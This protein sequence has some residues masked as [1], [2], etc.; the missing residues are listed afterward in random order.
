MNRFEGA[1]VV[2][3][4]A[5]SGLGRD[6]AMAFAREGAARVVL[7]DLDATGLQETTERVG[8]SAQVTVCD[9]S[10]PDEVSRAWST[11]DLPDGLDVLI[12]AAGTIGS[13][14]DIEHCTPQEWDRIFAV[15]V[16][17]TYL[18]IRSALPYLRKRRGCIVTFGSTAG[19]AG[20]SA[21]GPYSA[22]KGAITMMTRS[23]ALAHAVEGIRVNCA[24]PGSIDTPMLQ[25]TFDAAGDARATAE[26]KRMYLAR[27][28]MGRFGEAHEVTSAVL[29]LA[30][31]E[32][33][34]LTGVALPIDG[35]RLA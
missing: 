2:V 19:L 14:A 5:G 35:G 6:A 12:T 26:R 23:L 30:S 24:C 9:V 1:T 15:N 32:A 21:L 11:M 4:G 13:G 3:T 33:S 31:R 18:A 28:P 25:A 34:Y 22:S 7:V 17:G 29:F 20:S 16:R 8:P 27:Y 10:D